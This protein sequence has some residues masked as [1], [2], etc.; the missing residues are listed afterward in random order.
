MLGLA[1]ALIVVA[2]IA[3]LFAGPLAFIPGIVGI[4]LLV[5][6]LAGA[7]RRAAKTR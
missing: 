5:I 1:I 2:L 4:V 6:Y 7:G 3:L